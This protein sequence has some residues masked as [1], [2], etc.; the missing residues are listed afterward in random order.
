MNTIETKTPPENATV[1]R[2]SESLRTIVQKRFSLNEESEE[3]S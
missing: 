1:I 2:T 3:V